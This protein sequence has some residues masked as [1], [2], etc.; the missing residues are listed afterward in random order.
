MPD[1]SSSVSSLAL[2]CSTKCPGTIVVSAL[3]AAAV[4]RDGCMIVIGGFQS[5]VER[6]CLMFLLKGTV[7]LVVCPARSAT[8]MR[9][10]AVWKVA[11]AD[12]RLTIRS[13]VDEGFEIQHTPSKPRRLA[14]RPTTAL[15]EQRNRFVTSI[16]D[17]VLILHASPGGKLDHLADEVLTAGR[18][19]WTIDDPANHHLV[20]RGA[21]AIRPCDIALLWKDR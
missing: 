12:G 13:A 4:L 19:L 11:I 14:R 7:P 16:S 6:E 2:V 10:P 15:A 20:A 17:S 21:R 1:K 3:D 8:G 9:I 5:P 18:P